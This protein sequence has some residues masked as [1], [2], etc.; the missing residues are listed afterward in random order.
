MVSVIFKKMSLRGAAGTERWGDVAI[1][2]DFH[3]F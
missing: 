2:G 1:S 3:M